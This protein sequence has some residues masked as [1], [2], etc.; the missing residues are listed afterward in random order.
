MAQPEEV[1]RQVKATGKKTIAAL[2][3]GKFRTAFPGGA[4]K[5]AEPAEKKDPKAPA[6][7]APPALAQ[8][9]TTSLLIIVA[10]TDW[11]FDDYCVQKFD[12]M[13]QAAA[14]PF[15]DN[16]AFAANSLDFLSGSRDLISIRGKGNSV[17]SFTVVK[18]ME[19]EASEKYKEKLTALEARINEVQGKLADLQGKKGDSGKL[20]ASP[21]AARAI[22]DFQKQ[23]AE[24][25]GERREIR[26]SLREGID[27]LENRL[28][29]INLLGTPALVC[30]FGAWFYRRRRG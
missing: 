12:F 4:P 1:A 5:D 3:T 10:D 27:S 29:V 18:R 23:A 21:E 8:S 24:M 2:V 16:L 6:P 19:A 14:K 30:A 15:N 25:R 9:R 7:A 22:E 26:R 13:G 20:L 11:L 28:L 17:R